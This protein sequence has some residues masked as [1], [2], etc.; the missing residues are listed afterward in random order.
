MRIKYF[1]ISILFVQIIAGC[2]SYSS[3]ETKP[4][5]E[6]N[7]LKIHPLELKVNASSTLDAFDKAL[8]EKEMIDNV[9]QISAKDSLGLD[10]ENMGIAEL[11]VI[12]HK[13]SRNPIL[14]TFCTLTSF[15]TLRTAALLGIPVGHRKGVTELSLSIKNQKGEAISK[16]D[17]KG[18]HTSF[19][20]CYWG[21]YSEDA[22]KK[23]L[24]KSFQKA[25]FK[26]K[27]QLGQD[28]E[29][30]NKLLP[31]GMLDNNEINT[32]NFLNAAN[33]FYDKK[34]YSNAIQNYLKA[35]EYM[36]APKSKDAIS[37]FKLGM[38]YINEAKDSSGINA[39]K[40]F[41]K[42]LELN[43]TLDYAVPVGMYMAYENLGDD[44]IAVKW[45]DYA[46]EK[47]MLTSSQKE[48]LL[49]LKNQSIANNEQ[50]KAGSKL[51]MNPENVIVSNL[52]NKINGKE[53]DYFPSVTADESMLLFTSNRE[54][55]TGG[56]S[57]QGFYDEDL[58]Y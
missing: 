13:A 37:F 44:E 48:V 30:L 57:K 42:S 6:K 27:N 58:W 32:R 40:Y 31:I 17:V 50:L 34:N 43:P 22:E 49:K 55:S 14:S 20:T 25:M 5:S 2:R 41:T 11:S 53:S 36:K 29:A 56:I 1:I 45:L 9:F 16:Y 3:I 12:T 38:S 54:G 52:G 8:Y 24:D 47:F 4:S 39:I 15:G 10:K 23:A 51:K 7:A 21:Y 28:A 33:S 26:L 46:L 18:R 19:V 35:I